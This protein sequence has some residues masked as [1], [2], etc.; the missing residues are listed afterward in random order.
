MKKLTL[1]DFKRIGDKESFGHRFYYKLK[2]G[3]EVSLESCMNGYDVAIYDKDLNLIGEKTCTDIDFIRCEY[4]KKSDFFL[5]LGEALIKA[6]DIANN[7][8]RE[9]E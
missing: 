7:K 8:L 6:V 9:E 3:R 4:K 1:K 2:D 5:K